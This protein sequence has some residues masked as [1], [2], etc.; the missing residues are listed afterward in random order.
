[1]KATRMILM[2]L[3]M[4]SCLFHSDFNIFFMVNSENISVDT[5]GAVQLIRLA[6]KVKL[7]LS[8]K[9]EILKMLKSMFR[10]HGKRVNSCGFPLKC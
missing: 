5:L 9:G 4:I 6:E 2:L 7:E 8:L 1:M 3:V 10:S